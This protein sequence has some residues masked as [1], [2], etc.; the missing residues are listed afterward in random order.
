MVGFF[1]LRG[2]YEGFTASLLTE[3]G[4]IDIMSCKAKSEICS[5]V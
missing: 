2:F 5:L 3:E 1:V 4:G